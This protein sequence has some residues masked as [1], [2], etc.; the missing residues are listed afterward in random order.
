MSTFY[1]RLLPLKYLKL[2]TTEFLGNPIR[3]NANGAYFYKEY[4]NNILT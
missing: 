2:Q 4:K 3:L 1:Q